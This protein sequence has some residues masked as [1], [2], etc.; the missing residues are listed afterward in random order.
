MQKKNHNKPPYQKNQRKPTNQKQTTKPNQIPNQEPFQ[1]RWTA[2]GTCHLSQRVCFV[3]SCLSPH[4]RLKPAECESAKDRRRGLE[5]HRQL[6]SEWPV[7][8]HYCCV[9]RMENRVTSLPE[10]SPNLISETTQNSALTPYK[11]ESHWFCLASHCEC[12]RCEPA[13]CSMLFLFVCWV[14]DVLSTIGDS[15]LVRLLLVSH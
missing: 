7:G 6:P 5:A 11:S 3:S 9:I 12:G 10:F 8:L 4:W 2:G 15:G 1:L 13:F 14:P